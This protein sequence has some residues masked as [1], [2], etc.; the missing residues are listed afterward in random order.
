MCV[1]RH[2][3][4]VSPSII[5]MLRQNAARKNGITRSTEPISESWVTIQGFTSAAGAKLNGRLGFIKGRDPTHKDKFIVGIDGVAGLKVVQ[6]S[7]VTG[8]GLPCE[9]YVLVMCMEESDQWGLMRKL[10][11]ELREKNQEG[12]DEDCNENDK[13]NDHEEEKMQ[14]NGNGDEEEKMPQI[15]DI[16]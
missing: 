12:E 2:S 8:L 1:G 6:S 13:G 4:L 5:Q 15:E 11:S 7:Y 10:C 9:F 16:D 14:D 3:G